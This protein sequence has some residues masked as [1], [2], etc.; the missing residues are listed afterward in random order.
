MANGNAGV[1]GGVPVAGSGAGGDSAAVG[2]GG[3][4]SIGG[5][6]GM[7]GATPIPSAGNGTGGAAPTAMLDPTRSAATLSADEVAI[8]CQNMDQALGIVG[9][10]ERACMIEAW[11]ATFQTDTCNELVTLCEADGYTL[12]GLEDPSSCS[13]MGEAI[14]TCTATV[15]DLIGCAQTKGAFFASRTCTEVSLSE[16][17]PPCPVAAQCPDFYPPDT[18]PDPLP[19]TGSCSGVSESCYTQFYSFSCYEVDG[20]FWSSSSE[21]CS[22]LSRSCFLYSDSF[23]CSQQPGCYWSF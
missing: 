22:G 7:A 18:N 21:D 14:P 8:L 2:A 5:S 12:L 11:A 23:S 19:S 6:V 1:M 10:L 16:L 20:C 17:P 9:N 13:L 15:G 3:T 4:S